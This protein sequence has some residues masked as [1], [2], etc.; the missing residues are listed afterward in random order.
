MQIGESRRAAET[1]IDEFDLA[2]ADDDAEYYEALLAD[3]RFCAACYLY[4][5]AGVY[6]T[7]ADAT[8]ADREAHDALE[9]AAREHA[10]RVRGAIDTDE[11]AAGEDL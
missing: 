2:D 6:A 5:E 3:E 8:E 7:G 11:P 4:Q 1:I 9:R 10:Q